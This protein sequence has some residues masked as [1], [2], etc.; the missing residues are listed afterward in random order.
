MSRKLDTAHVIERTF[1]I[2][3]S[4]WAVLL[5]LALI[6]YLLAALVDGVLLAGGLNLGAIALAGAVTLVFTFVYNAM[7]VELVRDVQDGRLDQSV[8]E[9][10]RSVTP[11]LGQLVG[12]SLVA[13]VGIMAGLVL[14]FVPG[15]VL[16]AWWAVV[17]PVVIVERPGAMASLRRSRQLVRGNGW[18]VFGILVV[19]LLVTLTA[20]SLLGSL[21]SDVALSAVLSLAG[22]VLL[23]PIFAIASATMYFELKAMSGDAGAATLRLPAAP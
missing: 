4:H 6:V 12:A 1:A 14:F 23:A 2:Y 11:V 17:A 15:L 7:V 19:V 18:R 8:G 10:L 9:M 22:Q 3:A 20:R 5:G 13:G 21:S 16:I